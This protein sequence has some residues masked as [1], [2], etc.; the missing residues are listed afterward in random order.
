MGFKGWFIGSLI[1]FVVVFAVVEY[2]SPFGPSNLGD[3]LFL[4]PVE[5]VLGMVFAGS[6]LLGLLRN[7]DWNGLVAGAIAG[8]YLI[9]IYQELAVIF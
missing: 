3:I 7:D 8:L 9:A 2:T 1:L 6:L 5:F 4:Y